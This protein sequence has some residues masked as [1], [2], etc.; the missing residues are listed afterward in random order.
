MPQT[1]IEMTATPATSALG[2]LTPIWERLLERNR[3][4]PD[5]NFFEAGGNPAA[6]MELFSEIARITGRELPPMLIYQAPTPSKL[7][8]VVEQPARAHYSPL[9]KLR[10]GT[11]SPIFF[12]HGIGGSMFELANVVEQ[13]DVPNPIYGMQVRGLDGVSS[14][15]DSIEEMAQIYLDA[16]K[17]VQPEGPYLLIGYSLGGLVA[18]EIAQRLSCE[19]KRV[20]LLAMVDCYPHQRFLSAPQRLH[21][22]GRRAYRCVSNWVYSRTRRRKNRNADTPGLYVAPERASF[23]PVLER[24]RDH[25]GIALQRYRPRFY[26]GAIKFFRAAVPST[27][28]ENPAPVWQHLAARFE[29]ESVPGDHLGMITTHSASLASA[30]S[31]HIIE[32]IS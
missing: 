14:P 8:H 1:P 30:L 32:A 12:A 2:A 29:I 7:A 24:I 11:K 9:V 3:I 5:D 16:I 22:G 31:R 26:A 21:L 17:N 13:L 19:G 20:G 23:A 28:P 27:F 10:A 4:Q 25:A 6:A 18:L 15:L